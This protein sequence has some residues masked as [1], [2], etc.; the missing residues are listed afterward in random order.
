MWPAHLVQ[1][2]AK[3]HIRQKVPYSS[4]QILTASNHRL[5]SGSVQFSGSTIVQQFVY[6]NAREAINIPP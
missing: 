6:G 3:K 4:V 5:N 2:L 1:V